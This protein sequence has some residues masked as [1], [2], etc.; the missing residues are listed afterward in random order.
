MFGKFSNKSILFILFIYGEHFD[1]RRSRDSLV[2]IATGWT[3]GV[4]FSAG[5]KFFSILHIV[6]TGSALG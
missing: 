5:A 1:P 6:Q 4:R 3:A 2:G